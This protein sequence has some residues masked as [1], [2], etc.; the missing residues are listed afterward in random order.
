MESF[1]V[2]NIS[3]CPEFIS[4]VISVPNTGV[5]IF[6]HTLASYP[7]R[8]GS[9]TISASTYIHGSDGRKLVTSP[10]FG[11]LVFV[12]RWVA[13]VVCGSISSKMRNND[14]TRGC[15]KILTYCLL[16]NIEVNRPL[17]LFRCIWHEY[18][19]GKSSYH[20]GILI[21]ALFARHHLDLNAFPGVSALK[22]FSVLSEEFRADIFYWLGSPYHYRD[23]LSL[24]YS[25]SH[26]PT[27]R[28]GSCF[29]HWW[30]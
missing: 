27:S 10:E 30:R 19:V 29:W 14:K 2:C 25:S 17:L 21:S 20:H 12:T 9:Y 18:H 5:D 1:F 13:C 4:E 26:W 6:G 28:W 3:I 7:Y 22:P 24:S 16:K 15:H 23:S 11:D 8:A